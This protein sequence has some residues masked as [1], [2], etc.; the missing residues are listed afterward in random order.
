MKR[1]LKYKQRQRILRKAEQKTETPLIVLGFIW[2]ILVVIDL[3]NRTTPILEIIS[4]VIWIIFI[5]DFLIKFFLSP[6]KTKYLKNNI[7]TI[8]SLIIPAFRLLRIF[9]VLRLFRFTR[10]LRL[11]KIIGSINRGMNALA[12]TMGRRK[13]GY[14]L[15]LTLFVIFIGSAGMF[16]FEKDAGEG[17]ST[18]GDAIW[19]TGMIITSLGSEYWPRTVEGRVL[20]F[21]ISLYGFT[22]FGYF[23]AV[24]ASFFIGRDA[25]NDKSP[26]AG[27]KEIN[28][29]KE[30]I[31]KLSEIIKN[32]ERIP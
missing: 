13:F 8:I 27:S 10:G 7:I 15:V 30:E 25:E 11:F 21:I 16:A 28:E 12:S 1:D 3:L 26:V 2:L 29:L 6:A 9:R 23:T 24:L 32:N 20:G 22:V 17:F 19:W 14:V 18:F 4:V 5:I 31:R